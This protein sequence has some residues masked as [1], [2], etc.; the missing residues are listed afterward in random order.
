MLSQYPTSQIRVSPA[1]PV[2]LPTSHLV[3]ISFLPCRRGRATCH[4]THYQRNGVVAMPS[5]TNKGVPGNAGH[6]SH[7]PSRSDLAFLLQPRP[8]N[9]PSDFVRKIELE[10]CPSLRDLVLSVL[11][12]FYRKIKSDDKLCIGLNYVNMGRRS[13]IFMHQRISTHSH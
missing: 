11:I 2:N 13:Y 9:M 1:M 12:S 5:F 10:R 6:T 8:T 4:P 3:L 7:F